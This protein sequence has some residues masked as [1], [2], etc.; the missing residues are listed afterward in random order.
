MAKKKIYVLGGGTI[1]HVRPHLAL[2]AAAYGKTAI[3]LATSLEGSLDLLN[4]HL[5]A[6]MLDKHGPNIVFSDKADPQMVI[7]FIM[8]NFDLSKQTR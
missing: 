6:V 2:C 4:D 1:F 7:D 5:A 3:S 8:S